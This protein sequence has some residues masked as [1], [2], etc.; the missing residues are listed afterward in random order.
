MAD[1]IYKTTSGKIL[2]LP[3]TDGKIAKECCCKVC[4]YDWSITYDCIS[5]WGPVTEMA[6]PPSSLD[7]CVATCT[8]WTDWKYSGTNCVYWFMKCGAKG[9]CQKNVDCDDRPAAPAAKTG[10]PPA[11][12]CPCPTPPPPTKR[13][14]F[15]WEAIWTCSTNNWSGPT[16]ITYFCEDPCAPADWALMSQDDDHC[17]FYCSTCQGSCTLDPQCGLLTPTPP[18]PPLPN[19]GGDLADCVDC[20]CVPQFCPPSDGCATCQ[21][22]YTVVISGLTGSCDVFHPIDCSTIVGAVLN[23]DFPSPFCGWIAYTHGGWVTYELYCSGLGFKTWHLDVGVYGV[24]VQFVATN[25]DGCPPKTGW[26]RS[27]LPADCT[28]GS[29]ILS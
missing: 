1:K 11:D 24:C 16:M 26:V 5:G 17:Y 7:S 3:G 23:R 15:V 4:Q 27:G 18:D 22:H 10:T 29:M 21:D 19:G 25:C 13:C 9:E 28:G 12:E 8:D 2:K 14:R 20:Q 6:T